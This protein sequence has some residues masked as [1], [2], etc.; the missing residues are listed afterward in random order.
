MGDKAD[1]S[2]MNN[3]APTP[4]F[5]TT[6]DPDG[7]IPENN[8]G[9]NPP[10][11]T[12]APL[13]NRSPRM[14][15]SARWFARNGP[16]QQQHVH[17]GDRQKLRHKS[18]AVRLSRY[19]TSVTARG[20]EKKTGEQNAQDLQPPGGMKPGRDRRQQSSDHQRQ[21][22]SRRAVVMRQAASR[23]RKFN[24]VQPSLENGVSDQ[25]GKRDYERSWGNRFKTLIGC[26]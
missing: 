15:G 10:G 22:P 12:T 20:Q 5:C 17:R 8:P 2:R 18:A 4:E 24:I 19:R 13:M 16:D 7:P 1:K 9:D 6:S 21:H 23:V 25:K 11:R 14:N 3:G 26:P